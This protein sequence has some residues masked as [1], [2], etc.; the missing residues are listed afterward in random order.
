MKSARAAALNGVRPGDVIFGLGAG[1]QEKLLLVYE[2]DRDSIRA[3]H[4]TTQVKLKFDRNGH[5]GP[6]PGG[7]DCTIVSI[8]PLSPERYQVAIGLD[9]RART[10]MD[11]P[12]FILS[13]SEI[14]LILTKGDFYK[15]HPLP[16]E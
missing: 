4:V 12:Q 6:L 11:Q 2:V 10:E 3:R 9:R 5:T 13:K 8:A 16:E 7:G 14:E 1:G 15:A